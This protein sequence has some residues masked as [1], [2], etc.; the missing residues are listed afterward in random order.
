M[1]LRFVSRPS[2]V[3]NLL[4]IA[5]CAAAFG[6]QQLGPR[7]LA[8]GRPAYSEVIAKTS[9]EQTLGLIVRLRY[10]DP[11]GLLNVASVTANLQFSAKAEGQAGIGSKSS[12]AGNLVPFSAGVG[13]EDNPTIAYAPVNGQAFLNGWLTPV[14]LETLVLMMQAGGATQAR[15]GLLVHEM[16]GLRSGHSSS[17]EERA[18]FARAATLLAELRE[19]DIATWVQ[20]PGPAA[21]YALMLTGYAPSRT[22]Q[23]EELL[24]LL[25][26]KRNA[27]HGDAITIPLVLGVRVPGF[28]GLAIETRSIATIL[29]EA[30]LD[31]EV[32]A[33][34]LE[35]GVVSK[36]PPVPADGRPTLHVHSSRKSPHHANVAIWHRGY[37]YYVDDSD[38]ASKRLFEDIQM[39]FESRLAEVTRGEL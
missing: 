9:A 8:A 7:A 24:A 30:A 2:P 37:W 13:Y 4:A 12:Y 11:F 3:R 31:V 15:L 27:Q 36:S 39:L 20:T 35:A 19:R 21:S 10:L 22:G 17:S 16:N 6:C 18:G 34:H 26:L 38:L 29:D 28:D 23:V 14:S 1:P 25:A 5:A 33:E 32:P